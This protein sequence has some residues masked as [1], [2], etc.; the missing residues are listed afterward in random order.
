MSYRDLITATIQSQKNLMGEAAEGPPR[1]IEGLEIDE[2]G[3]V[4]EVTGDGY[5]IITKLVEAYHDLTGPVAYSTIATA[6]GEEYS[7]EERLP[8]AIE[9]QL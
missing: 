3:T 7:G 9:D 8:D 1:Q 5:E 6:L 4:T 2:E